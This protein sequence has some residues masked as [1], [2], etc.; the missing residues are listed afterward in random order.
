MA[1][2]W[3]KMETMI[4]FIFLDS[5][6][7]AD[8]DCRH[9]IKR[10]LLLGRKA[11]TNLD[12]VLKSRDTTLLTNVRI[13]NAIY[14]FSS[15]YVW[16]WELD[17][18]EGGVLKNLS[19]QNGVLEKTLE[20]PLDSKIKPINPEGNQHEYSLE[21]LML[22]LKLQNFGHLCEELTHWKRPWRWE[23]GGQE[24]RVTEDEMV[25]WH[26]RLNGHEFEQILGD[27]ER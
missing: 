14:D 25:G 22:K 19:F 20:S 7:T 3:G 24:K 16:I 9:G 2:R 8:V 6:I 23:N 21:R 10:R 4:D 13:V 1:S 18:K 12:S 26:H 11:T 15:S 17:H 5:K 27:S